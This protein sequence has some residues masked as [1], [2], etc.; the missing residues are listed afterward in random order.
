MLEA[1]ENIMYWIHFHPVILLYFNCELQ[2][3]LVGWYN[4]ARRIVPTHFA[5]KKFHEMSQT[6]KEHINGQ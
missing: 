1:N 3:T 6:R 2:W 5:G 4:N